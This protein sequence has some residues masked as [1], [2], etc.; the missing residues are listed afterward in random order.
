MIEVVM[1]PIVLQN[2]LKNCVYGV[3]IKWG[4]FLKEVWIQKLMAQI[5]EEFPEVDFINIVEHPE[6]P[7]SLWI[8]VTAPG[9][10]DRE[11]DLIEFAGDRITDIL[12]VYGYHML[13]M[14]VRRVAA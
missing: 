5:G 11:M 14:P 4:K 3:Y 2:R 10:E 12:L 6:D 13:V 1:R 8:N 7:E 9:D